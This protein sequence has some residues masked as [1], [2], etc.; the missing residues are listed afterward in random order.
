MIEK[1]I[2]LIVGIMI[3]LAGWTL[4]RT[5]ELSTTQAVHEDKIDKLER[6]TEKL[7]DQMDNMMNMDEEIMQQHEDLFRQLSNTEN[8][9]RYSY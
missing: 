5:F 4:S 6:L 3:A 7:K 8:S 9:E 2:T 1:V